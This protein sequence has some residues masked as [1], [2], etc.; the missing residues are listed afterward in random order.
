MSDNRRSQ[1]LILEELTAFCQSD[2][3]SEGGLREIIQR[4]NW[5]P[6][7]PSVQS[8]KFF[9]LT[10]RNERVTE[11]I[12]RY[13]LEYFPGAGLFIDE[14]RNSSLHFIGTNKNVTL[15]MVRLLIDA[16]P[17]SVRNENN[18]GFMPLHALCLNK[19]LNK[20]IG[21]DILKLLIEK[22]PESARHAARNGD[23][24]I[25]YAAAFQSPEFCRKL[26][27]VYPGSE[28]MTNENGVLPFHRACV[29][30]TVATAKYF[31]QL[32]PESIS[33]A[34]NNNGYY[35]IHGQLQV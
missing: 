6:N 16:F 34:T 15:G 8:Y 14:G 35:P 19:N 23:L 5:T 10:C 29:S 21:L 3:L 12:L 25:H 27:E 30:N 9:L 32:Y 1:L 24:S 20:E 33:V 13:L 7:N 18:K 17:A 2:S 28:R 31:Y 11:G 26:I 22:C 4:H